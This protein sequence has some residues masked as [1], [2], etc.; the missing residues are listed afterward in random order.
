LPP[1]SAICSARPPGKAGRRPS[2][3]TRAAGFDE[4]VEPL[5][6]QSVYADVPNPL[7]RAA[8]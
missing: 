7:A 3:L 2:L 1:H 5:A 8:A 4:L 6:T